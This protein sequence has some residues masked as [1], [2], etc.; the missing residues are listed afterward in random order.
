MSLANTIW[1]VGFLAVIP[2]HR[3]ASLGR[4]EPFADISRAPIDSSRSQHSAALSRRGPASALLWC[5]CNHV[6]H[7]GLIATTTTQVSDQLRSGLGTG[8]CDAI[9]K[10][11]GGS[12]LRQLFGYRD[13]D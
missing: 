4:L 5:S 8:S 1:N 6:P 11:F 12:H 9:G 13:I 7:S 10:P 3:V 2:G